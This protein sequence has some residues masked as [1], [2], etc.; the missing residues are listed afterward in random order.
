M[1]SHIGIAVIEGT[2]SVQVNNKRSLM[3]DSS[4]VLT[5]VQ[6]TEEPERIKRKNRVLMLGYLGRDYYGMQKNTGVKTIEEDLLNAL[7]KVNLITTENA[8]NLRT[9]NFQRA[10][11]TDK[12]VSAT[13]QIVSLKLPDSV[14]RKE[15]NE[16]LPREIRV[17]GVKRVTKGFNSKNQCDGRTYRYVIPTYAFARQD[18]SLLPTGE[19]VDIDKRME[20]LSVI[21]GKPYSEYRISTETLERV[22]ALLKCYEGTHN[23]HNFTSKVR[24]LDPRAIRYMISCHCAQTFISNNVE[25]AVI[26]IKGQSFMLHQI[27]KMIAVVIGISSSFAREDLIN[28]AFKMEKYHIPTAPSLGLSLNYVHYDRYNKRYGEDGIHERLDWEDCEDEVRKFQE[29][30]IMKHVVDTELS[31]NITLKWLASLSNQK[32]VPHETMAE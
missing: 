23:Y 6:K 25:F 30:Y 22:N 29:E 2:S 19:E 5:K 7:L 12:G 4:Q 18:S 20:Q 17:F 14:D 32:F 26:E 9:I 21:N 8:E 28:E 11:R 10:A 31:E 3:D 13:R 24:P 16:H 1:S 27:R 15:I